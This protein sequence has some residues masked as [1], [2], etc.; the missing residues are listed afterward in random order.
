MDTQ[1]I[2]SFL[3]S[4]RKESGKTQAELASLLGVTG[5]AVSKWERGLSVP[6]IGLLGELSSIFHVTIAEILAGEAYKKLSSKNATPWVPAHLDLNPVKAEFKLGEGTGKFVS[7][8]LFGENMEHTRSN[9]IHGL[10]AQMLSN[11]KF[12]GNPGACRGNAA[13]WFPIGDRTHLSLEGAYTKHSD[14]GYHMKRMIECWSQ[15][16][17]NLNASGYAGI[18]QSDIDV[19]AGEVYQFAIVLKSEMPVTVRISL[20]GRKNSE[21]YFTKEIKNDAADWT[22]YEFEMISSKSDSEAELRIE[23]ADRCNLWIGVVSM[24]PKDNFRGM[25]RDVVALLK[26]MGI[27][28]LRWP[29]GNFAGEYCW[30]D[31][32]LPVD[33]RAPCR[34]FMETE[35]QP[36]SFGCDT[37]ELDT[38][39]FIALCREIGAEPYITINSSWNTPEENA[40]WVEYCNGGSDTKWGAVRA[41]RGN[42]EP[43]HVTFWSLGNEIGYGHMEGDNTPVGY[44]KVARANAQAM[45]A[46]SGD[47][48]FCASGPYPNIDWADHVAKPLRG[49]VDMVSLHD[50]LDVLRY[51]DLKNLE[52]DCQNHI[53][54]V[55]YTH[56][57]IEEMRKQLGDGIG[58]SFDEWNVWHAWYR[59]TSTFEGIYTAMMFTMILGEADKFGI[60]V[61][62]HFEAVNEGA[63][64]VN[65]H[66]AYL[67]EMGK[68]F[69]VM[70]HH[71]GGEILYADH[72][73]LVT[74]KDGVTTVTAIN[75]DVRNEKEYTFVNA[76]A[77]KKG[78]L[79][80]CPDLL[81]FTTFTEKDPAPVT[82]AGKVTFKIPK[83]SVVLAQFA[84]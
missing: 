48:T 30:F 60:T 72:E 78:T 37:Q 79:Y 82:K 49:V 16:I 3:A 70:K 47:L 10:S 45:Q 77:F 18:G 56:R 11:R 71:I 36:H 20:T 66:D 4:C 28:L 53:Y 26:E 67:T 73:V 40:A 12:A 23:Y 58:I 8:Y 1:K 76:G 55:D 81:P 46:V 35:T 31:G 83:H 5:K 50:Y 64:V 62:C 75:A 52:N 25:R 17:L 33:Q 41:S 32:L 15:R 29:G 13:G 44:L 19:L 61:A 69:T 68:M 51:Q 42:P 6:D 39:D 34:S 22:R 38:D 80:T 74:K 57:R 21:T 9:I 59:P 65:A 7:P 14:E 84:N 27:K 54:Y 43:Y 2:G 63:I 24:M